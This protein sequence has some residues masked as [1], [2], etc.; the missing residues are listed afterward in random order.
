MS[1]K[2]PMGAKALELYK[3]FCEQGNEGTDFSGIIRFLRG[4]ETA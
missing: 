2:Q 3:S 1:A 4:A